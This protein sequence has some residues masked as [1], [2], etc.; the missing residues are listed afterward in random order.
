MF[1][2]D[3]H[4]GDKPHSRYLVTNIDETIFPEDAY[5]K[6]YSPRGDFERIIGDLKNGFSGDRLSCHSFI[7]NQ[8]RLLMA[9]LQYE[10]VELF[11]NYC[12]E[13]TEYRTVQP[14]TLRRALIKIGAR[15]KTTVRKLWFECCSSYPYKELVELIVKRINQIPQ[16]A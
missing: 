12:L 14:E 2:N 4:S 5:K 11:R 3:K 6:N 15:V 9:V 7:A 1:K 16:I 8:F 13:G 10:I